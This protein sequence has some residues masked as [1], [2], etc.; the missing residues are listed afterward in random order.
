M[1]KVGLVLAAAAMVAFASGAAMAAKKRDS[2]NGAPS[3]SHFTLNLVGVDA[4]K[5]RNK[6]SGGSVMFVDLVGKV[7]IDLC[8]TDGGNDGCG[9]YNGFVVIDGDATSTSGDG[10]GLFGLPTPGDADGD[11][12]YSLFIR[13]H[14][15][16]GTSADI[17]VCGDPDTVT[18]SDEFCDTGATVTVDGGSAGKK[19]Q[20]VTSKLLYIYSGDSGKRVPLF[21]DD[22]EDYYWEYDNNG[23]R[24]TQMRFYPCSTDVDVNVNNGSSYNDDKCWE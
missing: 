5:S 4:G 24:V 22:Y 23:L 6:G 1:K 17:T 15:K 10:Y 12:E 19:F 13:G 3:G 21:D 7:T 2:G 14:G 20:N 8:N 9:E 16:S 18:S 11:S